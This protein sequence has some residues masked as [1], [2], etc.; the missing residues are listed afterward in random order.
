MNKNGKIKFGILNKHHL[1]MLL[2]KIYRH[3]PMKADTLQP[4]DEI[5]CECIFP[6]ILFSI[7]GLCEYV[8]VC[9]QNT[10]KT[11][12]SRNSKFRILKLHLLEM[13]HGKKKF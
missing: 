2:E 7:L 3:R 13:L 12:L 11:N 4:M 9:Y 1:E 8:Y 5:C 10:S 6:R